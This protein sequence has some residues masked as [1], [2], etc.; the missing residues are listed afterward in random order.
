MNAW[1]GFEKP[2]FLLLSPMSR[3]SARN[4][5]MESGVSQPLSSA[6]LNLIVRDTHGG[7][8]LHYEA[9][10]RKM[11]VIPSGEEEQEIFTEDQH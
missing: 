2:L 9:S 1:A 6:V 5:E 8:F 3:D 4:S 7:K 11:L 10:P